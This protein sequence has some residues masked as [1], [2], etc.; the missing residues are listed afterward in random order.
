MAGQFHT[1][2]RQIISVPIPGARMSIHRPQY[3]SSSFHQTKY[4]MSKLEQSI[5]EMFGAM[6]PRL[7]CRLC[8]CA[9]MDGDGAPLPIVCLLE[10]FTQPKQPIEIGR[11]LTT[12]AK[13]SPIPVMG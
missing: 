7:G 13:L 10:E 9:E 3:E 4:R 8:P 6:L 5:G 2:Q 11:D 12:N 1:Q